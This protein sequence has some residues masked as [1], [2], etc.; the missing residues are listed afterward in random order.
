M[1]FK[2]RYNEIMTEVKASTRKEYDSYFD[3]YYKDKLSKQDANFLKS[4]AKRSEEHVGLRDF[5]VEK[6]DS[7]NLIAQWAEKGDEIYIIGILSRHGKMRREDLDDLREWLDRMTEALFQGKT[8]ITSPNE[9][10]G[11]F[12]DRIEKNVKR[13]D[14]EITREQIGPEFDFKHGDPLFK[15]KSFKIFLKGA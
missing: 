15:W 11:M 10:S 14:R 2:D 5:H 4:L 13:M 12:I 6:S 1:K 3:E 8:I 9:I 7:G